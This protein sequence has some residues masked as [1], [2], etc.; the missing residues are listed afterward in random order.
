VN[1]LNVVKTIVEATVS[2]GAGAVVGNTIK[3]TTPLTAKPYQRVAIG[4]GSVVLSALVGDIA[5]KKAT[6]Q[7][8]TT[9]SQVHD[10]IEVAK[11]K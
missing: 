8:D 1:K 4:I 3:A 6:D 7:I 2:L 11:K 5:S 10:L 9:V